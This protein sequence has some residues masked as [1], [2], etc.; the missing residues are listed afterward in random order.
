MKSHSQVHTEK[1]K[2]QLQMELTEQQISEI[3]KLTATQATGIFPQQ[4]VPAIMQGTNGKPFL[5]T[6]WLPELSMGIDG[7][8]DLNL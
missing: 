6:T 2:L 4:L 5:Q 8:L 7:S 1:K 3:K